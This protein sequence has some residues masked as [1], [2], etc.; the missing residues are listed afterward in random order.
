MTV[1]DTLGPAHE[2]PE[3]HPLARA[4]E[5]ENGLSDLLQVAGVEAWAATRNVSGA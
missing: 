1:A 2:L 4:N 3:S 5:T